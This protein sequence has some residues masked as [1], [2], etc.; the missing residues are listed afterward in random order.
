MNPY[1]KVTPQ[2]S[3]I[4]QQIAFR[5]GYTWSG[6]KNVKYTE[7]AYLYLIKPLGYSDTDYDGRP[8]Y[9]NPIYDLISVEDAIT[10]LGGC[11]TEERELLDIYMNKTSSISQPHVECTC[12]AFQ[13]LFG[14]HTCGY[15]QR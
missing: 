8:H 10:F 6:S 14:E 2:I 12:S 1:V 4:L 11:T 5:K 9:P 13:L 15:A 7:K 3:T